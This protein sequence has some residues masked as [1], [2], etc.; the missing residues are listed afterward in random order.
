MT[1]QP[2]YWIQY[3]IVWLYCFVMLFFQTII[4]HPRI[5]LLTITGFCLFAAGAGASILSAV[6]A[7]TKLIAA[8]TA[9]WTAIR[10]TL[11]TGVIV[12][13]LN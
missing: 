4:T 8:V 9:I 1:N 7:A 5:V 13:S 11:G 3:T 6:W 2:P 12:Q 10:A